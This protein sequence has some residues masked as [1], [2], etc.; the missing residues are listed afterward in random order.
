[1]RNP[2][3]IYKQVLIYILILLLC[4]LA[5]FLVIGLV[6]AMG[7]RIAN[8]LDIVDVRESILKYIGEILLVI[9]IIELIDTIVVYWKE[10]VVRVGAV[11]LVALTAVA[12]E[13]IVFDYHDGNVGMLMATALAVISLAGALFLVARSVKDMD[14]RGGGVD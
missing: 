9:I 14:L 2:L 10:H 6:Y 13:L 5:A 12:R 11:L 7:E 1:M 4:A 3:D 8:P